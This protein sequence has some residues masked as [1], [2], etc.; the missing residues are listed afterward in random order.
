MGWASGSSQASCLEEQ[1]SLRLQ[2]E[3][4]LEEKQGMWRAYK[5]IHGIEGHPTGQS[6][7]KKQWWGVRSLGQHPDGRGPDGLGPQS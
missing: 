3:R 1:E 7:G 2:G 6:E 4:P 5:R